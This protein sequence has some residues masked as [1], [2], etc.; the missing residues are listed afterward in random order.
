MF[1]LLET[2]NVFV[3]LLYF[4]NSDVTVEAMDLDWGLLLLVEEQNILRKTVQVHMH[5]YNLLN[6]NDLD[7]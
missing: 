5:H 3:H 4:L 6:K 1:L 7:D 2:I